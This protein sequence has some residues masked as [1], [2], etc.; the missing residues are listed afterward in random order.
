M[1]DILLEA[2]VFNLESALQAAA[3]GVDRIE[4]CADFDS[5]GTTPSLGLFQ[6]IKKSV[7]IPVF[8]MIRPRGGLFTYSETEIS[9]MLNDIQLFKNFGADGFVFGILTSD[10]MVDSE[11]CK[12]LLSAAKALPCTFHRAFDLCKNPEAALETLIELGFKRIL[13][14]G[15]Q[16]NVEKGLDN[17]VRFLTLA[18]NRIIILPGGGMKPKWIEPLRKTQMLQEVHASCKCISSSEAFSH[19]LSAGFGKTPGISKSCIEEFRTLLKN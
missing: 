2:P 19:P 7:D 13:T 10:G 4:L 12:K 8:V 9:V 3:F 1:A 14:S 6:E 15:A 5:G 17:L 18:K 11:N 16:P